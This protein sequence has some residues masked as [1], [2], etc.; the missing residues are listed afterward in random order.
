MLCEANMETVAKMCFQRETDPQNKL[1]SPLG[2]SSPHCSARRR[3][4]LS[5]LQSTAFVCSLQNRVAGCCTRSQAVGWDG[6]STELLSP[7]EQA[8]M[9]AVPAELGPTRSCAS[10]PTQFKIHSYNFSPIQSDWRTQGPKC[11]NRSKE[12]QK[13]IGGWLEWMSLEVFSSLDHFMK[14]IFSI[15]KHSGKTSIKM[16]EL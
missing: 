13:V 11:H 7:P 1:Q 16:L 3:A 4:F 6:M 15:A 8:G 12:Q 9:D 2:S 5:L 10:G 14:E